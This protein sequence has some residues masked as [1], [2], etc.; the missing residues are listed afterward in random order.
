VGELTEL[1]Q[2]YPYRE[3]LHAALMR[4]LYGAGR[5]ADALAAFRR[6]RQLLRDELGTD[7][8]DELQRLHHA[9]LNRD[10][11]L[12][13]VGSAVLPPN[14][15][16][17][18]PRELPVEPTCFVGRVDEAARVREALL[19]V[20]RDARRRPSVVVLY[21]PGGVGKSALAVRVAHEVVGEFP[22][23]QL[24]VDL[25]GSTPGM[26]PLTA[27][28]VLGRFLR[29]LGVAPDQI[30]TDEAEAA[31]LFRSVATDQRLLLVLDNAAGKDQVAGLIP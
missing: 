25:C 15:P 17:S 21:G 7:P 19:P 29:R 11:A 26:R 24:Y 9:I 14:P 22:D 13:P 23:G 30:P 8:S 5:P 12:E 20:D 6:A 18:I 31:A 4:A 28:E 1:V 2:R 3:G 10:P 27:V 16:T